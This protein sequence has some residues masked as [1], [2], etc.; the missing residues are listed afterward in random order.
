LLQSKDLS[1]S[2]IEQ[3]RALLFP[4]EKKWN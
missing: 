2:D 3:I 4:G 1:S